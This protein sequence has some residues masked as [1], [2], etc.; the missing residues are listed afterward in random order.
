MAGWSRD[1]DEPISVPDGR[2]FRTL[3]D[4]GRYVEALPKSQHDR[5]E[6]QTAIHFLLM[7][8]EG[9]LP[10]TFAHIALLKALDAGEAKTSATQEGTQEIPDCKMITVPIYADTSKEV[11]DPDHLKVFANEDAAERW[12]QENDPEGVVFE[13]EVLE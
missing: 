4:A 10:V 3:L 2:E 1:C 11:G 13:C 9:R 6:W 12:L 8:A 7:A 5:P